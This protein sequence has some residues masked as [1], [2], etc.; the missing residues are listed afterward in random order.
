M[1]KQAVG[2]GH[3]KRSGGQ[4]MKVNFSEL[5]NSQRVGPLWGRK[6]EPEDAVD[7]L[8]QIIAGESPSRAGT[9][10]KKRVATT[11]QR[12]KEGAGQDDSAQRT[13][14]SG[15]NAN[16]PQRADKSDQTDEG[17]D[18]E[19]VE[20]LLDEYADP[21]NL[22]DAEELIDLADAPQEDPQEL[23]EKLLFVLRV[24]L[25]PRIS[26]LTGII[27]PLRVRIAR[28]TPG[29]TPPQYHPMRHASAGTV[30]ELLHRLEDTLRG[31]RRVA[32][33]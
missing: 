10:D 1:I 14:E 21:D 33:K 7:T 15:A 5:L 31:L 17:I 11:S 20:E 16:A 4:A 32:G 24:E 2:T 6:T 23:L 18:E 9:A 27:E 12:Q 3:S 25:G 13:D 19:E 22:E 8:Q 29:A 26:M 28:L 30:F